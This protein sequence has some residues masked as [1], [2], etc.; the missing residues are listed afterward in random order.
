MLSRPHNRLTHG[1]RLYG[2]GDLTVTDQWP[3]VSV[4]MP[5]LNEE[6]GLDEVMQSLQNQDY[7]GEWELVA[8]DGGSEDQTVPGLQTWIEKLPSLLVIPS[9][10][11]R[12]HLAESLNLACESATGKVTVRADAHTIYQ[13]DYLR[14][15]VE[16]L[17][18][19]GADLVGGP[20]RPKGSGPF[21]K[22]VA[23]AMSNPWVVGPA[24][25]RQTSARGPADTVYLGAMRRNLLLQLGF[26]ELPSG[27]AEDADLAYRIRHM[28]GRVLLDPSIRSVYRPRSTPKTL[29]RQFYRYGK[30]KAEM[31]YAN[32]EL[33]SL[34]PLAPLA[35]VLGFVFTAVASP[36]LGVLWLFPGLVAIWTAYLLAVCRG[37]FRCWIASAIMQLSNGLGIAIGLARGPEAVR[38]VLKS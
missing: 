13:C 11:G 27:V 26:R 29:W 3:S 7:P 6:G 15:N 5:L 18:Q 34:R 9:P 14:R 37:N 1:G 24:R 20:M 35:L 38:Q 33:P 25:Y 17:Q 32:R 30:G 23:K 2:Y 19:S 10:A 21:A 4:L 31:L 8:V 12:R 16:A 36:T 22:A 28:G